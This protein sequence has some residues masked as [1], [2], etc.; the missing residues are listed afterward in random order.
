[1]YRDGV[2]GEIKFDQVKKLFG[3]DFNLLIQLNQKAE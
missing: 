2:L 1:M 3:E